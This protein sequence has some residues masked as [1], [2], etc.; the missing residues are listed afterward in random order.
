[1]RSDAPPDT[2]PSKPTLMHCVPNHLAGMRL[3]QA[4]ARM[5]PEHSRSR[6]KSWIE[7]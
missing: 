7:A 1:M 4:L 2:R 6:L 5:L 3:D